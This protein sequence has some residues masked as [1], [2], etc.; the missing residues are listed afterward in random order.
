MSRRMA[1][2]FGKVCGACGVG[3]ILAMLG[4]SRTAV[5]V[6]PE[7]TT[8]AEEVTT[9][10]VVRGQDGEGDGAEFAF[11]D[12]KGGVLLAKV[13]PP[14]ETETVRMDRTVSHEQVTG[15]ESMKLP[16]LPL[17]S[18]LAAMPRLPAL[19]NSP[20]LRPRLVMDETLGGLPDSLPLPEAPVLPDTGR[21][22]VPSP[23]VDEPIPL[24]LLAQPVSDRAS[25][26]DPTT[27]A[28]LTAA[29]SAIMPPR[30]TKAPFLK[31]TLPDPYDG[32]RIETPSPAESGEF[33]IG[34]PRTPG[35]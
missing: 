17:P 5:V 2:L 27:D 26:E 29:T 14:R 23:D 4:C 35:R 21:V 30:L 13:L 22:R 9:R 8:Q 7:S 16:T 25:L 3:M 18:T 28:S 10:A 32:R 1:A 33:P 24:P 12:D 20:P 11:P 31:Q 19:A 6:A 15:P 34:T